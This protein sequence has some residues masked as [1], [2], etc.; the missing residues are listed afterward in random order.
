MGGMEI[1]MDGLEWVLEALCG[2]I[3]DV[4]VGIIQTVCR[5]LFYSFFAAALYK[6]A[7]RE[8]LKKPILAIIPVYNMSYIVK[9]IGGIHVFGKEI[10]GAKL[11][12][13]LIVCTLLRSPLIG[14]I[15]ILGDITEAISIIFF[16]FYILSLHKLWEMYIP[17]SADSFLVLATLFSSIIPFLMFFIRNRQQVSS[18][19]FLDYNSD[20]IPDEVVTVH[21]AVPIQE[22][23][24]KAGIS[25][26]HQKL[27][28]FWLKGCPVLITR[29]EFVASGNAVFL[30]LTM[31]N[32]S[33]HMINAIYLRI[34]CFD[35]LQKP[36]QSVENC[37]L[38]D[39]SF[40]TDSVY[41]V[42][43]RIFLPDMN[44]RN[45]KI[46]IK[47][48]VFDT[49]EIWSNEGDIPLQVTKVAERIQFKPELI[50]FMSNK[51]K[52]EGITYNQYLFIP[53]SIDDYWICACGQ[54]NPNDYKTCCHCHIGKDRI[55][56]IVNEE[57]LQYE[58]TMMVNERVQ[59]NI[60]AKEQ[61]QQSLLEKKD[62]IGNQLSK[63]KEK[64]EDILKKK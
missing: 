59:R 32:I 42:K 8:K 45:C 47:N 49:N 34:I 37:R 24:I 16:F 38:L 19:M 56:E 43:G 22:Q 3:V 28:T 31:Q 15:P 39:L 17:K 10:S 58:Y 33:R 27:A 62:M 25:I 46:V 4:I 5:F 41:S 12:V 54:L 57:R 9:L 63:G 1:T 50:K 26:L 18:Q 61:I 55:I 40:K 23:N 30:D 21:N 20:G 48:I 11:T 44:T 52:N 6:L 53:V 7:V 64:I 2:K 14:L 29:Q 36:L 13:L 60:E 35:Y 51:L